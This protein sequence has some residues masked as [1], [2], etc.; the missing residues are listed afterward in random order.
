MSDQ[1][2]YIAQGC[3]SGKAPIG[4]VHDA[5]TG[6]VLFV[7]ESCEDCM[8]HQ[9]YSDWYKEENGIRPRWMTKAECVEAWW[10]LPISGTRPA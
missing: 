8:A 6:E 5:V 2:T 1:C 9:S 7:M 10:A 4:D 3:D